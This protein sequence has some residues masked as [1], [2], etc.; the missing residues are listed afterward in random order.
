MNDVF[1]Q[2]RQQTDAA[3]AQ[4]VVETAALQQKQTV[5]MA[6]REEVA[7]LLHRKKAWTRFHGLSNEIARL[8]SSLNA[9]KAQH[10]TLLVSHVKMEEAKQE[11]MRQNDELAKELKKVEE[12]IAALDVVPA[13]SPK[14][15]AAPAPK[16]SPP[17]VDPKPMPKSATRNSQ[18][19]DDIAMARRL[20]EQ[21]Y[22]RDEDHKLAMRLQ[23]EEDARPAAPP[24][25]NQ[26]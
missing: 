19:E 11:A 21:E 20:Q 3:L 8:K 9:S 24:G 22:R 1:A 15:A 26:P 23:Q 12:E 2:L 6:L 4:L 7:Q 5:F 14:P 18:L 10:A 17:K 25:G 13:P 16:P